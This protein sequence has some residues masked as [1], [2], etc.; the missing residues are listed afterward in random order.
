MVISNFER[1]PCSYAHLFL[2]TLTVFAEYFAHYPIVQAL[3]KGQ[4][5]AGG[6][7]PQLRA[8]IEVGEKELDIHSGCADARV[9]LTGSLLWIDKSDQRLEG[10]AQLPL[11]SGGESVLCASRFC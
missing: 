6:R 10:L 1:Q 11:K 2:L 7:R 9:K 4:F 8:G 5:H 3:P